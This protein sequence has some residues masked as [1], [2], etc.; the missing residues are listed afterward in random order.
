MRCAALKAVWISFA[1]ALGIV[2]GP[3]RVQAETVFGNLGVS[4]TGALSSSGS[5]MVPIYSA[6]VGFTTGTSSDTLK[7]ESI[8]LGLFYDNFAT[9]SFTL[10]LYQDNA[11]A[12]G[13]LAFTS[14]ASL[15]GVKDS[16]SFSFGQEQLASSTTYW[17]V[18]D[19]S[20]FWYGPSPASAPVAFNGSGYVAAGTVASTDNRATWTATPEINFYSVS[21]QAVPE[22]STYVTAAI[23]F[24]VAGLM[25]W[26]R[27][28]GL[29]DV[30]AV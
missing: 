22:P 11:G 13:A 1:V 16:Y 7:L 4:G 20:L 17:I 18:P 10:K 27:R 2:A 8:T 19:E 23:G 15:I 21:V 26:R 6:A 5:D 9:Q 30:S 24:G 3:A 12:P 29:V 28:K 14:S 25:G